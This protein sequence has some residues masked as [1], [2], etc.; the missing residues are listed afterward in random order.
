MLCLTIQIKR[1]DEFNRKCLNKLIID[2]LMKHKILGATVWN[3]F[4]GFG[5]RRRSL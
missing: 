1:N 3:G 4:D 5:R 2:Y